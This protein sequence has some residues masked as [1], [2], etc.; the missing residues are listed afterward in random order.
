MSQTPQ[1]P[2]LARQQSAQSLSML[3]LGFLQPVTKPFDCG[4]PIDNF[5]QSILNLVEALIKLLVHAGLDRGGRQFQR[6]SE[7]FARNP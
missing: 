2:L 1:P 3:S 6:I 5:T 7:P 4:Q